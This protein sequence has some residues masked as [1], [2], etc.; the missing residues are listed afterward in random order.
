MTK[1]EPI[2][3]GRA[4]EVPKCKDECAIRVLRGLATMRVPGVVKP[5]SQAASSSWPQYVHSMEDLAAQRELDEVEI[6]PGDDFIPNKRD[7]GDWDTAAGWFTVLDPPS[8]RHPNRRPWTLNRY[9][10]VI[11]MRSFSPPWSWNAIADKIGR[12]PRTAQLWFDH[13]VDMMFKAARA[14]T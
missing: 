10:R 3:L 2:K 14:K 7:L 1:H 12:S 11:A 5:T 9:Q 13:G 6:G 8:D 4:S